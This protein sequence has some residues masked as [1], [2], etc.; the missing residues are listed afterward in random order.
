M[1]SLQLNAK[2]HFKTGSGFNRQNVKEDRH[3]IHGQA[4]ITDAAFNKKMSMRS[5]V[6]ASNIDKQK[7][8]V[9]SARRDIDQVVA[10]GAA[11]L[12]GGSHEGLGPVGAT[13]SLH[14]PIMKQ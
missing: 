3:M 7:Q 9:P 4:A 5:N 10:F 8:R 2:K 14:G 1:V 11:G 13:G 6:I 12:F